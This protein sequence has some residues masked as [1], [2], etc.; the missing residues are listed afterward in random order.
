MCSGATDNNDGLNSIP[1]STMMF[2]HHTPTYQNDCKVGCWQHLPDVQCPYSVS[3]DIGPLRLCVCVWET[4]KFNVQSNKS[5]LASFRLCVCSSQLSIDCVEFYYAFCDRSTIVIRH[6]IQCSRSR[7]NRNWYCW[8]SFPAKQPIGA[9]QV[10]FRS[11]WKR[12]ISIDVV[13]TIHLNFV[14]K[15]ICRID[16]RIQWNV[17]LVRWS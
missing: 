16:N 1:N 17:V 10:M 7:R 15:S 5:E 8:M 13:Y 12:N 4:F 11:F 14:N 3:I 9:N 6:T 2:H